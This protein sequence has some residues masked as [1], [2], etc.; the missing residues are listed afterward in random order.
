MADLPWINA[1]WVPNDQW[2]PYAFFIHSSFVEPSV[3]TKEHAL[4]GYI[5]LQPCVPLVRY[6]PNIRAFSQHFHPLPLRIGGS[7]SYN[8]GN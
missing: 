1:L 6:C 2:D 8:A 5:N 3:F 4:D 7:L